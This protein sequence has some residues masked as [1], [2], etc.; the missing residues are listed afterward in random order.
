[1]NV[2]NFC[3]GLALGC[4]LTM[5][6]WIIFSLF[7]NKYCYTL[8]KVK[9]RES[10]A[11]SEDKINEIKSLDDVCRESLDDVCDKLLRG[12]YDKKGNFLDE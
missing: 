2:T 3:V 5:S 10:N 4:I 11:D 12:A 8:V 6:N 7:L 9:K 1:M